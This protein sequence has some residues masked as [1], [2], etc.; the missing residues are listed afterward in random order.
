MEAALT[1]LSFLPPAWI[2]ASLLRLTGAHGRTGVLGRWGDL[3]IALLLGLGV[4]SITTFVLLLLRRS[5]LGSAPLAELGLALG[6]AL[7]ARRRLRIFDE[8]G[9]STRRDLVI[10]G[11]LLAWVGYVFVSIQHEAPHG[12][13]D[14]AGIW[15]QRAVYLWRSG[16]DL[17][18]AFAVHVS[19]PDYPVLV[20]CLVVRA[21]VWAGGENLLAP[22]LV[23]GAFLLACIGVAAVAA[24]AARGR[25]AGLVA[26]AILAGT[27]VLVHSGAAQCADVPLAAFL[28]AALATLATPR[29]GH[30]DAL[31]AGLLLGLCAFTKNEGLV[32]AALVLLL[33]ARRPRILAWTLAGALPG[34]CA[35]AAQR[36]RFPA[37]NDLVQD[38]GGIGAGASR[39]LEP[40][41]HADVALGFLERLLWFDAEFWNG[42]PGMLPWLVAGV[43]AVRAAGL[44]RPPID[45]RLVARAIG[46]LLL[47]YYVVLVVTPRDLA[48]HLGTALSRLLLHTW[49]AF[50][51]A[52]CASSAPEETT[53][54][55]W[56]R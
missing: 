11:L 49:P 9:G 39:F 36:I 12:D 44:S 43:L 48:W 4:V 6:L 30:G 40:G 29:V 16:E 23:A 53:V 31:R 46:L 42:V 47:F 32:A 41:R 35:Y 7:L 14:A 56:N 38:L 33:H 1:L 25:R 45:I 20:P 26:A 22:M 54:L 21:W 8:L 18:P 15:N 52:L 17:T 19:H 51:Y 37:P 34:L 2:G 5:W 28:V 13:S 55:S 50:V 27:P 24:G 10:C 3:G